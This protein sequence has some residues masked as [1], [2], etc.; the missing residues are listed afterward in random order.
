MKILLLMLLLAVAGSGREENKRQEA[1]EDKRGADK[2]DRQEEDEEDKR[3]AGEYKI[4]FWN[5][6]NFFDPYDDPATS[7]DEFTREGDRR[8]NWKRFIKKR[9]DIAKVIIAMGDESGAGEKGYPVLVALAEVENRFVLDQLTRCSPL[10][11]LGYSVIHRNSPDERGIDVALLYRKHYFTP[12]EIKFY[13]VEIQGENK[14][15]RLILYTKGVLEELDTV[16]L[17]VNHW[18]SKFGGEKKSLPY[19]QCA[20]KTLLMICDSIFNKNERAN[21]IITGDFNDT[22]GSPLFAGFKRF[23]NLAAS[24]AVR[25]EG[26]IKYK[27]VWEMIDMFFVSDNLMNREEPIACGDE[28]MEIVR[29]PFLLEN[30]P[31]YLG[32]R[33]RRCYTGPR[34]NSGVS[35]HLPVMIRISIMF[36]CR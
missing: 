21:I 27:G 18:P 28:P 34:Y 24:F 1:K 23:V 20:A 7:D 5:L 9:N 19:R 29:L 10:A 30:D 26:S 8:W 15:T 13:A 31:V 32:D 16:H 33:P 22:P 11:M 3:V 4:L 14:K 2:E 36:D 25:G 35:D 6:E 17:F 12:L